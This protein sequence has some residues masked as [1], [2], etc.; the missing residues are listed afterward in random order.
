MKK[1]FFFLMILLL[2]GC[3]CGESIS[4]IDPKGD[5]FEVKKGSTFE[6]HFV[7]NASLGAHWEWINES[8]VA[9]VDSVGKRFERRGDKNMVGMASDMYIKFK[10]NEVGT[11]T[12]L[13]SW[14]RTG[15]S[16]FPVREVKKIVKVK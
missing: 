13:F 16:S 1:Y 15:D 8:K 10:A 7:T 14:L 6:I 2:A 3:K 4:Q 5:Y 11:D 12:L 9:V